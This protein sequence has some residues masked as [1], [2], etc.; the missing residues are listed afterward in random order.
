MTIYKNWTSGDII[1][2]GCDNVAGDDVVY[3]IPATGSMP[4]PG[5]EDKLSPSDGEANPVKTCEAHVS[6]GWEYPPKNDGKVYVVDQLLAFTLTAAGWA[7]VVYADG[8]VGVTM[9]ESTI[10]ER[11]IRPIF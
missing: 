2:P 6:S 4:S 10:Y 7:N 5:I 8:L 9:T 1:V 3:L 11:L